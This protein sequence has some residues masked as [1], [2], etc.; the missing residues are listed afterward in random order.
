M[1]IVSLK[2]IS[3]VYD[4][5]RVT[6]ADDV[7]F[8][9]QQGELFGIIGPCGSGKTTLLRILNALLPPDSGLASI[10]GNDVQKEVSFVRRKVG[11]MPQKL[12]LY[13][14]MTVEENLNFFV[15]RYNISEYESCQVSTRLF[16]QLEPFFNKPVGLLPEQVKRKLSFFCALLHRPA[17]LLLDEPASN[18]NEEFKTEIW[19]LLQSLR[20]QKITTLVA[21]PYLEDADLFDRISLVKE[22]RILVTGSP[23][24]IRENYPVQV[25]TIQT[26]Q[27]AD[28]MPVFEKS[29]LVEKCYLL[30]E[31]IH[32]ILKPIVSQSQE[33]LSAIAYESGYSNLIIESAHAGTAGSLMRL[34]IG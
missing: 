7:S 14:E 21:S 13:K 11:Y 16:Y 12:S 17:I 33:M 25:F 1:E 3:K 5:G 15:A 26:E 2:H 8:E 28:L 31:K 23:A 32:V 34:I 30:Y 29:D 27:V 10:Y 9:V 6:G 4:E 18:M 19:E 20:Q 22:G 24:F